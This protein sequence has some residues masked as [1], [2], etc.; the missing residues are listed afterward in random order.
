LGKGWPLFVFRSGESLYGVLNAF[1]LGLFA[2]PAQ[3]GYFASAEKISRAMFGL[4]NPIREA[5][6]PRL[7]SLAHEAP[8]RAAR[9]ARIGVTVMGAGGVLLSSFVYLFAPLLIRLL[10]GQAF[11][12]AVTVLRILSILPI[13]LSLTHSVGLQ[14]LLP[15]GLDMQVNR[16]I[17]RAGALNVILALLVAPRFFHIGM[18]WAVVSAEAFVC[19]NMLHLALSSTSLLRPSRGAAG[20][21]IGSAVRVQESSL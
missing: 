13:L 11:G 10:M 6:Y 21:N 5:I 18:A 15:L 19:L 7:S 16:V 17:L 8:K 14:G 9:L 1:I 12:P 2:S 20:S 4:L 3:V